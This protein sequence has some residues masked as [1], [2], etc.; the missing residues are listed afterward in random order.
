MQNVNVSRVT[1]LTTLER[2]RERH[3]SQFEKAKVNYRKKAKDA[4]DRAVRRIRD[5]GKVAFPHLPEPVEYKKEYDTVIG[6][7]RMS[8]DQT[9]S[10]SPTD[11]TRFVKDEWEWSAAFV[12]NTASYA[13]GKM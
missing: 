6:M 5:G 11:Y 1:L 2:N 3:V 8:R 7:L 9:I 10:L 13:R 12:S 4:L